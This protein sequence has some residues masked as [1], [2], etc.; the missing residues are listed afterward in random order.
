[1][2]NNTNVGLATALMR[3][4]AYGSGKTLYGADMY[5][6]KSDKRTAE[7][8]A[9]DPTPRPTEV[10]LVR[11]RDAAT[12]AVSN[13][14]NTTHWT[15]EMNANSL[16]KQDTTASAQE[17]FPWL[18]AQQRFYNRALVLHTKY[19]VTFT[20]AETTKHYR[21]FILFLPY[22]DT[23]PSTWVD[24]DQAVVSG[25]NHDYC[26]SAI[27]GIKSIAEGVCDLSQDR[28]LPDQY[29]DP[30]SYACTVTGAPVDFGQALPVTANPTKLL[31]AYIGWA[32][33]D[34]TAI[35]GT[36]SISMTIKAELTTKFYRVGIAEQ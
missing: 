7:R 9:R 14:G 11:Y 18:T 13:P 19:T 1:M 23:L 25:C 2:H 6:R 12:T 5:Q 21:V 16:Y 8:I 35:F 29:G 36:P 26:R 10:R 31:K 34:G 3:A 22:T 30:A 32:T 4:G 28:Y 20:S 24:V 15:L 17:K 27:L 33:T